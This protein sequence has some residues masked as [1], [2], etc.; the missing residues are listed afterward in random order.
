MDGDASSVSN[1]WSSRVTSELGGREPISSR[2]SV[3][4]FDTKTI[5]SGTSRAGKAKTLTSKNMD[6]LHKQ[7]AALGVKPDEGVMIKSLD[8]GRVVPSE[9]TESVSSDATIR[10]EGRALLSP[11]VSNSQSLLTEY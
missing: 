10:K 6:V 8:R 2:H 3:I 7:L 11:A 5:A 4:G 1:P 9:D